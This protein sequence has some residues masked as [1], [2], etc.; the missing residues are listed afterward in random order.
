MDQIRIRELEVF[1]RHGV[2]PEENRLGQ[3]FLLDVLIDTETREAGKTDDITQSIDYAKICRSI[4][5]FMQEH[6][7][8][9]I[10]A[11]AEEI[12]EMLLLNYD[13][14]QSVE[15]ELKKPWAP[16]GLPVETVSVRIKRGWHKAYIA[17]G[18]NMGDKKA[19][20]DGALDSIGK[21]KG[22]QLLAISDWIET[23]AY[24]GVEQDDFLN[25]VAAVRTI[26]PPYALLEELQRIEKEAGRER[27]IHWGPRTLD[28][29]ILFYDKLI[30][31][32]EKLVIPHPDL[33]NRCFVLDP[34][35]QLAPYYRHPVTGESI[36][37]M[38]EKLKEKAE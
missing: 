19:F 23:E 29:D 37:E 3:K 36:K 10:E 30:L 24:G 1:A 26:L 12:A 4:T 14:I 5:D 2:L 35:M 11:A 22:C 18:S 8:K 13:K 31:E 17:L 38:W 9:L 28:L 20:L 34:M 16:I 7:Y 21:I 32:E 27:K 15:I 6:T 25:G 33:Q